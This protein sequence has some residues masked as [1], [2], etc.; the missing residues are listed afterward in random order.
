[1]ARTSFSLFVFLL[2]IFAHG[3]NLIPKNIHPMGN[4]NKCVDVQGDVR[5]NGTPVQVFDC[6]GSEAQKWFVDPDGTHENVILSG[7]SFCLDAGSTPGNFVP[8]KI[9]QCFNT[10]PQQTWIRTDD[11][12]IALVNQGLCLD[13]PNGNLENGQVLQTFKCTDNDQNQFF[14]FTDTTDF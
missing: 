7:G 14:T 3:Q 9:W 13:V 12:R 1:M 6:N 8:M 10:L 11:G 5:A 2:P 4:P